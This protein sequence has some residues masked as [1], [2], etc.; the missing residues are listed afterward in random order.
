MWTCIT[1]LSCLVVVVDWRSLVDL[2]ICKFV[3]NT[4]Q[5][6]GSVKHRTSIPWL[7]KLSAN[8][9]L[10]YTNEDHFKILIYCTLLVAHLKLLRRFV[11]EIDIT[12][13]P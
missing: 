6:L 7:Q 4:P 5:S 11:L 2:A 13:Y 10:A 9:P 12:C 3:E 8:L 1:D